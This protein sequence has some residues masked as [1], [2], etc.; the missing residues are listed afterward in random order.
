M[1]KKSVAARIIS[2]ITL[3][4][5]VGI[6]VLLFVQ[7]SLT[8]SFFEK[9]FKR[10]YEEKTI[11][12]AEQMGGGIK[13]KKENSI[14]EVFAREVDAGASSNLTDVLVT[15]SD[16][17]PLVTHQNPEYKPMDLVKYFENHIDALADKSYVTYEDKSHVITLVKSVDPKKDETIGYILMAWSKKSALA[18]LAEMRNTTLGISVGMTLLF[19]VFLVFLIQKIAIKPIKS[20]QSAMEE[21]SGGNNK[22]EIP[23]HEKQDE[24]GAMA[25]SLKVF[26][27]NAIEKE[28][29]ETEQAEAAK[30]AEIEKKQTMDQL[31]RTF[32][33]QV[34]GLIE[35]LASAATQLQ[36]T[37]GNMKHIADETSQ[38]S[39]HVA[40][41]SE[42]ASTNVN[43][44]ASAMEEMSASAAEIGSQVVGAKNRSNDTFE[45]AQQA[46]KTV[47]DLNTLVENIGQVV[48]AIQ[49]IAEQTNLL[50]LNATIEAARAG[51][52]GKGFAVVADEVK[53]L[54]N[55]TA[56]K[57]GEIN[58]QITDIQQATHRSVEAM[59]R[60]IN[61]ISDIDSSVTGVSA[62]VEE[63]TAT[64]AEIV[65]SI[66]EASMGVQQVAQ[67]IMEVQKGA[68]ETGTSADA[69]LSASNDLSQ[70]SDQLRGSVKSF[71]DGI[72]NS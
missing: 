35:S 10:N 37:S 11:L 6:G 20:L 64:T 2:A 38:A 66:S 68:S 41:A 16:K 26:K 47:S 65:R 42:E 55:E 4:L 45:N 44:V 53:K 40:A 34:G 9:E 27:E 28:L 22:V 25:R 14:R 57:T 7:S 62:A 61:N 46:N 33:E 1:F 32:D 31:A 69:V 43:T 60:I 50:A 39:Q 71:L 49:D 19:I 5:V 15:D 29:L 56:S 63:Q 67:V 36:Q 30:R 51:E 72:R 3:M 54:A 59:Q 12:F 8:Q 52:A 58:S 48:I 24:I 18:T 23:F 17:A 70:L 21:L 13:W